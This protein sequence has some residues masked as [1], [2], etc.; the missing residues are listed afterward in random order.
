MHINYELSIE[1]E[2]EDEEEKKK[3]AVIEKGH[4]IR[5]NGC[6]LLQS[7]TSRIYEQIIKL[8][9]FRR[10]FRSFSRWPRSKN[11]VNYFI[12]SFL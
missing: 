1:E 5:M 10:L 11:I 8:I 12:Y 9:G 6:G 2:E 4:S 3:K 7:S